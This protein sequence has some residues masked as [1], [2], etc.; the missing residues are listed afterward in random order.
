MH[1][2]PQSEGGN[3]SHLAVFGREAKRRSSNRELLMWNSQVVK[4]DK[5]IYRRLSEWGYCFWSEGREL[6]VSVCQNVPS[7][8]KEA[9]KLPWMG[10]G[11]GVPMKN[12]FQWGMKRCLIHSPSGGGWEYEGWGGHFRQWA[13]EITRTGDACQSSI[14]TIRHDEGEIH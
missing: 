6:C 12:P 7:N 3:P 2:W 9:L 1:Y 8:R 14:F 4:G 10:G 13:D 11:S 5:R